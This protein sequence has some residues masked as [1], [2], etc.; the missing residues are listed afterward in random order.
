M[1]ANSDNEGMDFDT[2]YSSSSAPASYLSTAKS[3][4]AHNASR[5]RPPAPSPAATPVMSL[6]VTEM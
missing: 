5:T 6:S 1:A 3:C 4:V 2:M